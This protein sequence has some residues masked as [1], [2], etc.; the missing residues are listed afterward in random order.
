M[1]SKQTVDQ[2]IETGILRYRN[3]ATLGQ[4]ERHLNFPHYSKIPSFHV[5]GIK[6]ASLKA[7]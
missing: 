4:Y 1:Y 3:D 6:P 7:L 5:D 2:T